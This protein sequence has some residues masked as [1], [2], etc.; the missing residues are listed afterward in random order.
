MTRVGLHSA[1]TDCTFYMKTGSCRFGSGCKFN[2]P[3]L[4]THSHAF[5]ENPAEP[6]CSF[7][8][9]TGSCRFGS[10]CKFNHPRMQ[11]PTIKRGSTTGIVIDGRVIN[12]AGMLLYM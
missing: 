8:M 9:K 5:N 3:R 10:G 12:F 11:M 1:E 2:H 7:Y 6:D 4:N